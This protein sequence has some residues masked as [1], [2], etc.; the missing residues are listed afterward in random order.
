[1]PSKEKILHFVNEFEAAYST[2]YANE[3]W[4]GYGTEEAEIF[5]RNQNEE[6]LQWMRM[7]AA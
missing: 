3:G 4:N 7:L 2:Y 1:M 6:I 5:F